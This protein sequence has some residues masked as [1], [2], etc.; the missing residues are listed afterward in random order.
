MSLEC[1]CGGRQCKSVK[2]EGAYL[3]CNC[4]KK[5]YLWECIQNKR[6]VLTFI[7][8]LR[9]TAE[10]G[11]PQKLQ[12]RIKSIIHCDSLFEFI[13]PKCKAEGNQRDAINK[14]KNDYK[15]K[16]S[17]LKERIIALEM[18]NNDL[19]DQI[20][21]KNNKNTMAGENDI[22]MDT[23]ELSDVAKEVISANITLANKITETINIMNGDIEARIRLEFEKIQ[24]NMMNSN[25]QEPERKRKRATA[26]STSESTNTPK[27]EACSKEKI[28]KPK[29][30][31]S[32]TDENREVYEIYVSKFHINTTE[33]EIETFILDKTKIKSSDLFKVTKLNGLRP[34]K[35]REYVAFKITTL[36]Y[37]AYKIIINNKVWDPDFNAR[38]FRQN[39][40]KGNDNNEPRKSYRKSSYNNTPQ[41]FDMRRNNLKKRA[42]HNNMN[43]K[44]RNEY[45]NGRNN[46][47]TLSPNMR[48]PHRMVQGD[49][50]YRSGCGYQM[51]FPQWLQLTTNST[52]Y[53]LS[54]K[55]KSKFYDAITNAESEYNTKIESTN[56]TNTPCLINENIAKHSTYNRVIYINA[57]SILANFENIE[58]M[59]NK[60]QPIIMG[61]SEAR[62]TEDISKS[63]YK[64]S[65]YN[66]VECLSHSRHT[67][68]TIF[69]VRKNMKFKVLFN[70]NFDKHFWFI[71][72][73][74]WDCELNGIYHIFYRSQGLKP[75]N[76]NH[77][78]YDQ[79]IRT[80]KTA[81]AIERF[82]E[83][84]D[85]VININKLNIIMGDL[86]FDLNKNNLN[87]RKINNIFVKYGL[88]RLTN[89]DTRSEN[90]SSS[91]IDVVLTNKPKIVQCKPLNDEIITDHKTLQ[92]TIESEKNIPRSKTEVLTW[93]NYTKFK[94]IELLRKCNWSDF[95]T[96][97][98]NEKLS[99]IRQNMNVSIN[100][101]INKIEIILNP[102]SKKRW[103]DKELEDLKKQKI[104]MY[105]EWLRERNQSEWMNYV[106]MRNK[107][108]K[109]IKFKKAEYS[110]TEIERVKYDQKKMW[111]C[112]N[113]K[114]SKPRCK[115]NDEIIFDNI[116]YT[117]EEII[118]ENFNSFFINSI[119]EI[120]N[121]IP[122][123]TGINDKIEKCKRKFKFEK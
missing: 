105:N 109:I 71:S 39:E 68:G 51:M 101:L 44:N 110:K 108:S 59:C 95:E 23:N 30:P 13:C 17:D 2:H 115:I 8:A 82:D 96:G 27:N 79:Q 88:I 49:S 91:S 5:Q 118:S 117:N 98:I 32:Y 80:I 77:I 55:P 89:F 107:Y 34:A 31:Q 12:I 123:E 120:S 84:L 50:G 47:Q 103:F 75:K 56:T 10:S 22:E 99:I 100:Q 46:R 42:I 48:S 29:P 54:A 119:L 83:F 104:Q 21:M 102:S 26:A 114:I 92:I 69:Y 85:K 14:M 72:I 7:A 40:T 19:N 15:E 9:K 106:Q 94:M 93:R 6:E 76:T 41:R 97:S 60:L 78:N 62:I 113:E 86:N 35:S 36:N 43:Q 81:E 74:L 28:K 11:T 37:E 38:D 53:L 52:I 73:E 121:K 111:K 25:L 87:N 116:P 57:R 45:I 63:E 4:C 3:T 90:G 66:E 18:A 64:I 122:E 61:C 20:K 24:N 70:E 16:I 1:Q 112:L 67:G 65:G 33:K 58:I